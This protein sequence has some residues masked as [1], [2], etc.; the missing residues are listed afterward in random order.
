MVVVGRQPVLDTQVREKL[1]AAP[2]VLRGDHVDGRPKWSPDG[3]RIAFVSN[4]PVDT[5]Q[6]YA[7]KLTRLGLPT[8]V[9]DVV[10]SS[11]VLVRWLTENAG[12]SRKEADTIT[13]RAVRIFKT[14]GNDAVQV[15]LP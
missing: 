6:S 11:Q 10:N 8:P 5:R 14:Y 9:E 7:D 2:R 12:L 4:K 1:A 3:S 13:A 15:E